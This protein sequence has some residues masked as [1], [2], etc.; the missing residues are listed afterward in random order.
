MEAKGVPCKGATDAGLDLDAFRQFLQRGRQPL[1][2][3]MHRGQAA[4]KRARLANG[5]GE[6]VPDICGLWR[7]WMLGVRQ[8]FLQCFG[9]HH[10]AGQVLAQAV[11]QVLPDAAL[12]AVADFKNLMLQPFALR[13]VLGNPAMR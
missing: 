5:L 13:D 10:R 6:Q 11:V 12:F 9:H 2:A 3:H 4:G 1:N 8:R 7:R